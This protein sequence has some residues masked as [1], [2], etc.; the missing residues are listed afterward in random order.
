M[1]SVGSGLTAG[2]GFEGTVG[3]ARALGALETDEDGFD[4]PQA[5]T[6]SAATTTCAPSRRISLLG[7]R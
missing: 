1:V 2:D 7:R 4:S 6:M 5:A 3:A